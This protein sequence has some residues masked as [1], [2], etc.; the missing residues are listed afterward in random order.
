MKVILHIGAEKT[1]STAL[2]EFLYAN[3]EQLL[4]SGLAL[5]D[6]VNVPNNLKLVG[7]CKEPDDLSYGYF[8]DLGFRKLEDKVLFYADFEK[9]FSR[10]ISSLPE[11]VHTVI[12]TSEHFHSQIYDKN[13]IVRLKN[14]LDRYFSDVQIVC[15]LREQ[16]SLARSFYSTAIKHGYVVLFEDFLTG[17]TLDNDYY[18]HLNSMEKWSDIFGLK[19]IVAR[20][21]ERKYLVENDIRR[22][23]LAVALGF[24]ETAKFDFSFYR[25]NQSLGLLGA[26]FGMRINSRLPRHN[27]SGRVDTFRY[28]VFDM[29]E[30]SRISK[31]GEITSSRSQE[32]YSI[33]DDSNKMFAE[34]YLGTNKNPFSKP[35]LVTNQEIQSI[36]KDIVED[37]FDYFLI[38]TISQE[39]RIKSLVKENTELLLRTKNYRFLYRALSF[40]KKFIKKVLKRLLNLFS[41]KGHGL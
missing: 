21:Y 22:D 30:K 24:V 12:I 3:R 34:K 1:G 31:I 17:A 41:I 8:I 13:E 23:F 4:M 20:V 35:S 7:Y 26:Q 39:E 10:E 15:Y 9:E 18:N 6:S 25:Q 28:A 16:Y 27:D 29:M 38:F 37:L 5:L 11:S 33:F 2:Q 32:I 19:N 14:F 36:E 40:I